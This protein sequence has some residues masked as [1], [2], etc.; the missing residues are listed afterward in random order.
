MTERGESRKGPRPSCSPSSWPSFAARCAKRKPLTPRRLKQGNTP[1]GRESRSRRGPTGGA[2]KGARHPR[3]GLAESGERAFRQ[4]QARIAGPAQHG[5]RDRVADTA[6]RPEDD[7]NHAREESGESRADRPEPPK[8]PP[9][10]PA[11]DRFNG[12]DKD[13]AA[14][15][16]LSGRSQGKARAILI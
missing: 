15:P 16:V 3:R 9:E 11:S 7:Q 14:D 8:R 1:R 4:A 12:L 10:E 5:N 2:R 6:R 13:Q